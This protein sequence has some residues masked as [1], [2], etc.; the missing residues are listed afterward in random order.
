ML[1]AGKLA[2]FQG[3]TLANLKNPQTMKNQNVPKIKET[4]ASENFVSVFSESKWMREYTENLS[5]VNAELTRRFNQERVKVAADK[6]ALLID[7]T[8]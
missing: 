2:I 6:D 7:W 8:N 5:L 3:R 4:I 1:F